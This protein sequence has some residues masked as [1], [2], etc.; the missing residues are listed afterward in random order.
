MK[1]NNTYKNSVN[2]N[3][4]PKKRTTKKVNV[5]AERLK[6]FAAGALLVLTIFNLGNIKDGIVKALDSEAEYNQK[7]VEKYYESVGTSLDEVIYNS[8]HKD[9]ERP[10]SDEEIYQKQIEDEIRKMNK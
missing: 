9:E 4:V 5:T 6:G 10:L 2:V 8:T 7:R 3:T 1:N